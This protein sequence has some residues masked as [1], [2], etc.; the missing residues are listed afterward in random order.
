MNQRQYLKFILIAALFFVSVGGWLLHLRIHPPAA[1]FRNYVPFVA[2]TVNFILIPLLFF[3]DATTPYAYVLNGMVVITGTITMGH[4]S[5]AMLHEG[6]AWIGL[7]MGT[8]FPDILILWTNFAIGKALFELNLM[9]KGEESRP[10]GR[11]FRYPNMGW[12][13]AH[14]V[15]IS[16]VYAL[17]HLLWR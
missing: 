10:R 15:L 5:L 13:W 1:A 11:F 8:L 6:T 9:R 2:G 16:I 17:G 4:A 14:L 12:W 3:F 7:L